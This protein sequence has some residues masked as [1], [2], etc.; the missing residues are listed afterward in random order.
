MEDPAAFF[1]GCVYWGEGDVRYSKLSIRIVRGEK[2]PAG[3]LGGTSDAYVEM[4]LGNDDKPIEG[5][6]T[7]KTEVVKKTLNPTWNY[8]ASFDLQPAK[9][10][11]S[12]YVMFTVLDWDRIGDPDLL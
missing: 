3:D 7:H 6:P 11:D 12:K 5:A 4:T 2:L 10:S 1:S 9:H 8:T